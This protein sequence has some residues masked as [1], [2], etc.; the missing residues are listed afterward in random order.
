MKV[1]IIEE[2]ENPLLERRELKFKVTHEAAT[3]RREEV[4]EKL[5]ALANASGDTVVLASLLPKFGARESLGTARIYRSK[6]QLK[7]V[8]HKHAVRKNFPEEAKPEAKKEEKK[9]EAKK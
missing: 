6:E 2:R 3:P 1:E 5:I 8:E 4:R 9:P 7:K